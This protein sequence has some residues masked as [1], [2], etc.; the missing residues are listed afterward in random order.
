MGP[1][2][3]SEESRVWRTWVLSWTSE[4]EARVARP[5]LQEQGWA[6]E[7]RASEGSSL[8]GASQWLVDCGWADEGHTTASSFLDSVVGWWS[9]V[10]PTRRSKGAPCAQ[11]PVMAV[12]ARSGARS[13]EWP[14]QG[15]GTGCL[16]FPCGLPPAKVLSSLGMV[17]GTGERRLGPRMNPRVG[18]SRRGRAL[19]SRE[20]TARIEP[21]WR[22][23]RAG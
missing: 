15:A 6:C 8:E 1:S 12:R 13:S 9:R 23:S 17:D 18:S 11:E 3:V 21:R 19:Q 20:R 14:R 7:R 2:S 4:C 22:P 16:R 10:E 5:C